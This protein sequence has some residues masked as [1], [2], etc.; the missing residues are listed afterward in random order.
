LIDL[1]SEHG[2][3]ALEG[4]HRND[5]CADGTDRSDEREKSGGKSTP[6]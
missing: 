6:G 1:L 5:Q 2:V 3:L 4:L